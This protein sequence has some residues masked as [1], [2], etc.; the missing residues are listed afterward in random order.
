[1]KVLFLY[2]L[3]VTVTVVTC[4]NILPP[5]INVLSLI[6]KEVQGSEEHVPPMIREVNTFQSVA[7]LDAQVNKYASVSVYT[8][9]QK[10]GHN[11]YDHIF[12][13]YSAA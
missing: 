6:I 3:I 13:C 2:W 5:W 4:V 7:K 10:C 12:K 1:M 8:Y 11:Y 9:V